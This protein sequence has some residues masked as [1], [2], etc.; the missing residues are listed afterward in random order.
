MV[1]VLGAFLV[2]FFLSLF[3]SQSALSR[4]NDPNS[5]ALWIRYLDLNDSWPNHTDA[6]L[7]EYLELRKLLLT[8]EDEPTFEPYVEW[9][10]FETE[11]SFL[12]EEP[13]PAASVESEFFGL[14]ASLNA[15]EARLDALYPSDFASRAVD[16]VFRRMV[17]HR[18]SLDNRL[19]KVLS[20]EGILSPSIQFLTVELASQGI[21]RGNIVEPDMR[22][23]ALYA[24]VLA[25]PSTAMLN[26]LKI[27]LSSRNPGISTKGQVLLEILDQLS[28][29]HFYLPKDVVFQVLE[30]SLQNTKDYPVES[31]GKLLLFTLGSQDELFSIFDEKSLKRYLSTLE[32]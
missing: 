6:E 28:E 31:F 8:T 19:V 4:P 1:R 14:D 2:A 9:S 24:H 18:H 30:K 10:G 27:L 32:P 21:R 7:S 16:A 20:D 25:A 13:N 5:C 23:I 29:E 17:V 15:L 12:E 11:S 26:D 3:H 22:T